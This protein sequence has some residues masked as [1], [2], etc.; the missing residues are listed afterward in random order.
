MPS[1][2]KKV[3]KAYKK[4][5]PYIKAGIK[6]IN[7]IGDLATKVYALSSIVNAE[8]KRY[9]SQAT[10]LVLGQVD[11]NATG[12][13]VL[14]ITPAPAQGTTDVTRNGDSIKLHSSVFNFQFRQQSA[15][16]TA[17]KGRIEFYYV[18]GAPQ[19]TST[20][21]SQMYL[22]NPWA[23]GSVVVDLSS[24]INQDYRQQY[25][26]IRGVNVYVPTDQISGANTII[27]VKVPLKYN[28]GKGHHIKY[29]AN[30][31]T[32]SAGM[33]IAIFRADRGN[34]STSTASTLT[35]LVDTV[36]NSGLYFN[37]NVTHYFYDN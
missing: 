16:A 26:F 30:S 19:A 32:I 20:V 1:F 14:D 3:K 17:I 23:S 36:I 10:N 4:A 35:G 18:L 29:N 9:L 6:T 11:G 22:T 5:K 12:C 15:C 37:Y 13:T 7:T 34:S 21:V 28:F 2:R 27:D 31:T 33:I 24:H 8:K 25:K